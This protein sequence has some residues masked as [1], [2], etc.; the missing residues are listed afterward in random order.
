MDDITIVGTDS[1]S[2]ATATK[3]VNDYC[4]A[5]CALINRVTNR[6]N[7]KKIEHMMFTFVWGSQM[8]R[9]KRSTLYKAGENGGKGVPD[10]LN[11]IRAQGLSN[12]VTN[13]HKTDREASYF[14]R[15]FANPILQT[16]RL[17]TIDYTVPY[18]WDP[19]TNSL[20]LSLAVSEEEVL[21][22]HCEQERSLS[23][24]QEKTEPT[25]IKEEEALSIP[26]DPPNN[27]NNASSHSTAE[28]SDPMGLD[29]SPTLDPSLSLDHNPSFK[30]HRSKPS[31]TAIKT[32]RCCDCGEMF[33]L[34]S[35]LQ[36]HVTLAKKR[37]SECYNSTCKLKA[38]CQTVSQ[39]ENLPLPLLCCGD[40][41]KS[42]NRRGNLTQHIQTHTGEKSFSC[43]D[44][45]KSF[46]LKSNL[47]EH[48][49]THTG[50][51]PFSCGDCGKSFNRKQP[52]NMHNLTYMGDSLKKHKLTHIGEEPFSCGDCG[53][54]FY[55]KGHLNVH[56]L[57]H[58]GEKPFSCGDCGKSFS[59]KGNLT[60]HKLTH[61]GEEYGCSVCGKR[62]SRT[63][64][65]L[66]HMNTAHKKKENRTKTEE[67]IFRQRFARRAD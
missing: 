41:G 17:S 8:E 7:S 6:A 1:R 26:C 23:L 55:Q 37:P 49:R 25:Q 11:I 30:K 64:Q 62:F 46:S 15:Y 16:L 18:S 36:M 14:E 56:K 39:W 10:I 60:I 42:V 40:C 59:V 31:T 66:K 20:Q 43:G 50:E 48:V 67:N 35:D 19:P 57:T 4:A 45:G 27:Q 33:A 29:S 54:S 2:I 61:T 13:I 28:S 22:E 65:L 63:A 51:K 24:G 34:K 44:C 38:P 52:L 47:T 12:L 58:T 53:K 9:L 5:T 3:M 32:L 21:P